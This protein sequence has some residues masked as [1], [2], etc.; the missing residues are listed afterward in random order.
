MFMIQVIYGKRGSGKTKRMIDMANSQLNTA[1]GSI[2]F[3][4]DDNRCILNLH[5]DIRYINAGEYE[6]TSSPML[7]GFLCG[8]LA[9]DFDIEQIYLDGLP[10]LCGLGEAAGMEEF[11]LKIKDFSNRFNVTVTMG[12][13]GPAEDV[14]A[15]LCGHII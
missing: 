2:V 9:E 1:K 8:I 7:Y 10:A 13:S 11:F 14:P 12:V 15:F 3:I 6:V 4:D 5:H